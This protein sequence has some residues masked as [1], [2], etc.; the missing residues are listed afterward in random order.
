MQIGTTV[1]GFLAGVV[2]ALVVASIPPAIERFHDEARTA[3]ASSCHVLES[4][5]AECPTIYAVERKRADE[6]GVCET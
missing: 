2:F 1:C 3:L 6:P 4:N 5:S